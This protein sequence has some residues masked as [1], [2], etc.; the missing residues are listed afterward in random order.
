MRK[1]QGSTP[2]FVVVVA[3]LMI[4]LLVMMVVYGEIGGGSLASR[5]IMEGDIVA[6]N[7]AYAINS[8]YEAGNGTSYVLHNIGND[9][10]TVNVAGGT[11]YVN[12]SYELLSGP[13]LTNRT[14]F[15]S[16]PMNSD[17]RIRN[18]DGVIYIEPA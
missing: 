1:A 15:S 11:V 5:R 16:A 2:E 17:V 3:G 8:V 9:D 18:V 4:V 13:L 10:F 7:L 6:R 14:S 12:T